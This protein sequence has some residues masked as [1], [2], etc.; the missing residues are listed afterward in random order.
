MPKQTTAARLARQDA[1]AGV[2]YTEA[3]RARE[4]GL[5]PSP[6]EP[7]IV[8]FL[9]ERSGELYQLVGGIAAA[10]AHSGQRVLLLQEASDTWRWTM[11]PRNRGRRK[12]AP[13]T[14]PEPTTSV[15]WTPPA[16]APGRLA[17]RTCMWEVPVPRQEHERGFP[18]RDR[19][20]LHTALHEVEGDYD[21]IVMIPNHSWAYP[22]RDLNAAHIVLANVDDFPDTDCRGVLPGSLEEIGI[23]LSPEQS[24]AVLRE[25]YL[26][27]LFNIHR[28]ALPLLGA[29]WQTYGPPPVEEAYLAGIDRDMARVGLPT[30]GWA[31]STERSTV[32]KSLPTPEQLQEP[33]FVRRYAP[34][35]TRMRTALDARPTDRGK[36]T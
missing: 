20:Q 28:L 12:Q 21:L 26:A 9:A 4:A 36:R 6:V 3:L 2:K 32:Y 24:A 31:P 19:S 14:P 17:H 1:R 5:T 25:R 16:D 34:I 35:A 8:R 7:R 15:L 23:P 18:R 30:L 27:F 13:A 10:W 22:E 33:A 29:V 11:H